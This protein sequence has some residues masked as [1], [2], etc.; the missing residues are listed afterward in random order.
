MDPWVGAVHEL[1]NRVQVVYKHLCLE[2]DTHHNLFRG[3]HTEVDSADFGSPVSILALRLTLV[4]RL[5]S[6]RREG[7]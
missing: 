2:A 1:S 7:T 4:N 5:R 3:Y 6:L